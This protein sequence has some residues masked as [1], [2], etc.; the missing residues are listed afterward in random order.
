MTLPLLPPLPPE[1]DTAW[2]THY[3]GMDLLLRGLRSGLSSELSTTPLEIRYSGAPPARPATV[4]PVHFVG[5]TPPAGT[6]TTAGG[7]GMV[8]ELDSWFWW[9]AQ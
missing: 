7:P 5:P 9:T 6:G 4:R 2:Y 1:G 8:P 3:S